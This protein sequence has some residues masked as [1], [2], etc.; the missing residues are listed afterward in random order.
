MIAT[1]TKVDVGG[2]GIPDRLTDD[3]F[4]RTRS[5]KKPGEGSLFTDS[6]QVLPL[7][8]LEASNGNQLTQSM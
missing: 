6:K 2:L 5:E 1:Q 7:K 8:R 3:Y 4:R